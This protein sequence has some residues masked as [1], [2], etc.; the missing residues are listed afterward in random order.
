MKKDSNPWHNKTYIAIGDSITYGFVPRNYPGYPGKLRSYAEIAAENLG[1]KI[2]NY[3]ISGDFLA[4]GAAVR[5]MCERYADMTDDADLI[6]FMGGTNDVRNGIPLGTFTDRSSSTYYGA[7]HTLIQGLYEKYIA[8]VP[9]QI[10]CKRRIVAITP[11]KL[12]DKEKSHLANTIENNSS[13]LYHWP[14]WIDA[15]KEVA[16]FYSIPV[17][18]AYNLS[19]INPHINRTIQGTDIEYDGLYN[20]YITD[21]T[22]PTQEGHQMFGDALSGFLSTLL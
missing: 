21:G 15:V 12:L 10:G 6:T 17:F 5:G 18:D 1:M 9:A 3:G 20:P 22:H 16:A 11:I 7:L 4:H 19:C 8:A 2:C 14:G 13:S